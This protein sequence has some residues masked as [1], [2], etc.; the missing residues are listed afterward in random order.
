[1]IKLGVNIDHVATVREARKTYE[2]DPVRAAVLVELAGADGITVHLR[3][4]RR[5]I[6]DRDLELLRK[7]IVTRL[8]LEM[9]AVDE[10][11]DIALDTGPEQ[12]TLVPEKREEV[13]TEGGLDVA[14]SVHSLEKAVSRLKKG[15]ISVSMFIDPDREQIQAS[16]DAGAEFVEL[17]T[18]SYAD[19]EGEVK[20]RE[21]DRLVEASVFAFDKN[22]GLNA[23]H[24][25]T[26]RNVCP[27]LQLKKLH[28]LNIGHSIVS[29]A[30]F[31][32]IEPAVREMK[33]LLEKGWS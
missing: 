12:V 7:T 14:G 9:A 15:G 10:I 22:I 32:G 18:G 1:M 3:Q 2:P 5:H 16:V 11:I 27:V 6:Q 31:V 25:L 30:L 33:E 29:R 28:E 13:T 19:A 26:Y 23:G 20:K 4:D 17:H 24:G 21:L 8:N